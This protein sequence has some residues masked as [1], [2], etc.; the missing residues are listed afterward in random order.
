MISLLFPR[1]ISRMAAAL[2][3]GAC[4][5]EAASRPSPGGIIP[6]W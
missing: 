5:F 1:E 2:A 4:K 6:E 3:D